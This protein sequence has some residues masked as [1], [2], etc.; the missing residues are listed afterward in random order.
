[1]EDKFY[2]PKQ[3][4]K[5]MFDKKTKNKISPRMEVILT[6]AEIV[7]KGED[8]E[9]RFDKD[10]FLSYLKGVGDYNNVQRGCGLDSCS[11]VFYT[12]NKSY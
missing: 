10:G 9:T 8:F 4:F 6:E 5:I 1:M 7:V 12:K 11:L 2:K 3:E